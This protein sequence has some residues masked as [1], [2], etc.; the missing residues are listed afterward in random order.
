[1]T[2]TGTTIETTITIKFVISA[3]V[4]VIT[5]L[6]SQPFLRLIVICLAVST[7][8]AITKRITTAHGNKS[9]PL[10]PL[11]H[12]LHKLGRSTPIRVDMPN[13]PSITLVNAVEGFIEFAEI[14]HWQLII[15]CHECDDD[16]HAPQ[17]IV[18]HGVVNMPKI[19]A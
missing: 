10:I 9:V 2:M 4:K 19:R 8:T 14:D 5:L 1:M 17:G 13:L 16:G 3:A 7:C 18:R 6:S 15:V 11:H 12:S